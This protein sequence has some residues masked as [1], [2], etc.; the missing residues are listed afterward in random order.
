MGKKCTNLL[1]TGTRVDIVI[2]VNT[3][4]SLAGWLNGIAPDSGSKGPGFDSRY[5]L[6][7]D[8]DACDLLSHGNQKI[9]YLSVQKIE[10]GPCYDQGLKCSPGWCHKVQVTFEI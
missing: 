2:I 10:S 1:A 6:K 3:I 5:G 9:E 7:L 8:L 4:Q